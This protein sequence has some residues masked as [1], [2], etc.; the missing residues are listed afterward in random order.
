M[1]LMPLKQWTKAAI[2]REL[3]DYRFAHAG[4]KLGA[5]W[6]MAHL[7]V[8]NIRKYTLKLIACKNGQDLYG[9]NWSIVES[10]T[11]ERI[12]SILREQKLR[13]SLPKTKERFLVSYISETENGSFVE[14]EDD[15]EP[16]YNMFIG[17]DG[18]RHHMLEKHLTVLEK[19][20]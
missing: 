11:D 15:V 18:K 9:V 2:M 5:P 8:D 7:S 10:F 13:T 3:R 16:E 14:I 4:T 6:G 20:L 12:G 17:K 1:L 19:I